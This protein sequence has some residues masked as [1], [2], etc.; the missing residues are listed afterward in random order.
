MTVRT[1][2]VRT[3]STSTAH[4]GAEGLTLGY[5]EHTVVTDLDLQLPPGRVTVIVGPNACGKSTLLRALGR[6]LK[7]ARGLVLL[8]GEDLHHRPTRWVAQQ[9]GVLAQTPTAPE[10]MTVFD[11]VARGRQPHQRWWRQWSAEDEARVTEAL[12][13]TG[14]TDLADRHVDELSGG[15][16]QRA[17]IAMTIAQDTRTLLLD[18]PTTYLDI[19]HQIE[20]LDLLRRLNHD[21]GR[22]IVAV[23]HDL[24]QAARYAD[25]LIM[26]RDGRIVAHGDPADVVTD[27]RVHD[28]FGLE[29]IVVPDPVTATPLIV[30]AVPRYARARGNGELVP[31]EPADRIG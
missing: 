29:A 26:M 9:I 28:V 11:L 27:R 23:L 22:T 12:H 18:E 8:D 16:R 24:N 5:A 6:L 17:W 15:Q 10:G 3:E 13:Q 20:V 21:L 14:I 4:L 2:V 1:D 31:A 19:A 30:P 7:P 25:H